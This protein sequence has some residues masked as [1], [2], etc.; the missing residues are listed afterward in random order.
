MCSQR[1][2]LK[3]NKIISQ[4]HSS[5]WLFLCIR[6]AR[7]NLH[8]EQADHDHRGDEVGGIGHA[9][10]DLLELLV[11]HLIQ[12]QR[13]NNGRE[14]AKNQTLQTENDGV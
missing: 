5:S 9:L 8:I 14:K 1:E 6:A 2:E 10:Y 3:S 12:H 13:E 7:G 4:E 11:F